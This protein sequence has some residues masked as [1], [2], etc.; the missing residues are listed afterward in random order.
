MEIFKKGWAKSSNKKK[1]IVAIFFGVL[2]ILLIWQ[3]GLLVFLKLKPV[4][5]GGDWNYWIKCP[6]G[7]YCKESENP[8]AG[9]SCKPFFM[10]PFD[11]SPKT[12]RKSQSD[13]ISPRISPSANRISP[14]RKKDVKQINAEKEM[15]FD[16]LFAGEVYN[17]L[18][19]SQVLP[20]YNLQDLEKVKAIQNFLSE[21]QKKIIE[22]VDYSQFTVL[23]IS[24]GQV[25]T[26]GWKVKV[27]RIEKEGEV[28]KIYLR[29]IRPIGMAA[30]VIS[31]P[32]VVV[33]VKKTPEVKGW[34]LVSDKEKILN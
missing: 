9:G 20:I 7:S 10:K 3:T 30:E 12:L 33:K 17:P 13:R 6:F 22:S 4:P 26:A 28:G 18:P 34:N 15:K 16:I 23:I 27:E 14:F 11:K 32:Y 5:C 31:Y 1:L 19:L 21:D 24:A 8:L 25:A 2:F 29:K